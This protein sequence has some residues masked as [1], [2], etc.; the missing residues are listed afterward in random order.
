MNNTNS[1]V[2]F[3][4]AI[5]LVVV[6][7]VFYL[8][9]VSLFSDSKI[10]ERTEKDG[11]PKSAKLAGVLLSSMI[12]PFI[13]GFLDNFG[14]FIGAD[15]IGD[16]LGGK[17]NDLRGLAGN[18]FSDFIGSLIGGSISSMMS[19]YTAYD[20]SQLPYYL[21]PIF[22]GLAIALGCLVPFFMKLELNSRKLN[23]DSFYKTFTFIISFLAIS[24][25][26]A[27]MM[28]DYFSNP[29][30]NSMKS[31]KDPFD[32]QI[33]IAHAIGVVVLLIGVLSASTGIAIKLKK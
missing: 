6:A 5:V 20:D 33:E 24:A 17:D 26:I 7:C 27:L 11:K 8:V 15:S 19:S 14:M 4:G 23:N 18:T 1:E 9:Y 31:T 29:D 13:F 10:K 12:G 2:N 25:L 16:F 3:T 32:N 22:E 28:I 30:E 21:R